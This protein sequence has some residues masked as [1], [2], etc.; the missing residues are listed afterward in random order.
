M[1]VFPIRGFNLVNTQALVAT[2]RRMHWKWPT[3]ENKYDFMRRLQEEENNRRMLLKCN[4]DST[5]QTR[6]IL[7]KRFIKPE[8]QV[9]IVQ[10]CQRLDVG[11]GIHHPEYKNGAKSEPWIMCLG[12]K[13]RT[14]V[15]ALIKPQILRWCSS[16]YSPEDLKRIT[17]AFVTTVRGVHLVNPTQASSTSTTTLEDQAFIMIKTTLES[18]SSKVYPSFPRLQATLQSSCLVIQATRRMFRR[19]TSTPVVFP[20]SDEGQES[21]SMALST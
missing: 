8:D 13:Y 3:H 16:L 18:V 20:Y 6:V 12:K 1:L 21:Y 14:R 11:L 7:L 5:L 15:H 2:F 17:Q 9:E 10:M 4:L 19:S